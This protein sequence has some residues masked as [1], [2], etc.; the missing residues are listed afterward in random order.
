MKIIRIF[1]LTA[2][3][4]ASL[5]FGGSAHAACGGANCWIQSQQAS[6]PGYNGRTA[7]SDTSTQ[8]TSQQQYS[9]QNNNYQYPSPQYSY[10]PYQQTYTT[11]QSQTHTTYGNQTYSTNQYPNQYYGQNN[12]VLESFQQGTCWYVVRSISGRE[13]ITR[14]CG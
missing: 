7:Y 11:N 1:V 8:Y 9:Y 12:Q 6:D 2:L 10:Q 14:T 13:Y 3:L 5:A 4:T